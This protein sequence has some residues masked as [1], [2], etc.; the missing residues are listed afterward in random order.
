MRFAPSSRARRTRSV[1]GRQSPDKPIEFTS[2]DE[3]ARGNAER[4]NAAK[5]SGVE[6]PAIERCAYQTQADAGHDGNEVLERPS[7]EMLRDV[8]RSRR[9]AR[10]PQRPAGAWIAYNGLMDK[11]V[12]ESLAKDDAFDP[13]AT[14]TRA[15]QQ[16]SGDGT[17]GGGT[18]G[19]SKSSSATFAATD[20]GWEADYSLLAAMGIVIGPP[21]PGHKPEGHPGGAGGT[22]AK[23]NPA[24]LPGVAT[25][26]KGQPQGRVTPEIKKELQHKEE[27]KAHPQVGPA[28]NAVGGAGGARAQAGAN[29]QTD[30]V[31]AKTGASFAS[32]SVGAAAGAGSVPP[33]DDAPSAPGAH[34]GDDI[35]H[36][37][38]ER[39]I[40]LLDHDAD[41]EHRRAAV[42]ALGKLRSAKARAALVKATRDKDPMVAKAAAAALASALT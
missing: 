7:G 25:P 20:G 29:A 37:N 3:A 34:A 23:A 8:K 42:R 28:A 19:T 17:T 40:E 21:K 30:D 5:V 26:P 13:E 14:T 18:G 4:A 22:A 16:N 32:S 33:R 11:A 35:D 12:R 39:L 41:P 1:P 2:D 10:A 38:A 24:T 15:P 36:H 9:R 31:G 6:D 27:A